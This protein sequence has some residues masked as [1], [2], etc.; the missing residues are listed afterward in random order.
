MPSEL[1]K[2]G[3]ASKWEPNVSEYANTPRQP[4]AAE[5]KTA[6]SNLL[7]LGSASPAKKDGM[8]PRK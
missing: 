7:K 6:G 5:A 3:P 2:F 1:S 8:A 4:V